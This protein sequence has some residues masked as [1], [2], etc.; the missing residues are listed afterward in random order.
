MTR[1]ISKQTGSILAML[2]LPII[3]AQ[4]SR[5]PLANVT[6]YQNYEGIYFQFLGNVRSSNAGWNL[7]TYIDLDKYALRYTELESLYKNTAEI[8]SEI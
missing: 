4:Y 2:W 5:E 7:V 1:P 8:C 3:V 6:T